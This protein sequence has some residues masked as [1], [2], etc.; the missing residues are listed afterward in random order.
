M[1]NTR[2]RAV[3]S[4]L[5]D[6]KEA[7]RSD[8]ELLARFVA[9]K[10]Q[11]AFA[12]LVQRHG[13]LVLGVCRRVLQHDADAE[14]AFQAT[15]LLLARK[16]PAIRKQASVASWLHGVARRTALNARRS[17]MRRR[18]HEQT[19]SPPATSIAA[20][21]ASLHELQSILDE[22]V[23]RLPERYRAPFVLCC[24]EGHGRPEAAQALG[25]SEGTVSSRLARA[26]QR[27]QDRLTRRGI[28]LSTALC[29]VAVTTGESKAALSQT[30]ASA[31]AKAAT[32]FASGRLPAGMVSD[33]AVAWT[34][35]MLR[36]MTV[37]KLAL[38]GVMLL[39]LVSLGGLGTF[40]LSGE[41][42]ADAS[43]PAASQPE[44]K[45]PAPAKAQ[46]SAKITVKSKTP[47]EGP[48]LEAEL[49]LTNDGDAPL[50]LC[51]LVGH[52]GSRTDGRDETTYQPDW[53]K[54]DSPTDETSAKHIVTL[55][56]GESVAIPLAFGNVR[57]VKGKFTVV[58]GYAVGKE[59]AQKHGTWSGKVMAAPV[60]VPIQEVKETG[61]RE[62]V[63]VDLRLLQ[64]FFS[65]EIE[66]GKAAPKKPDVDTRRMLKYLKEAPAD[67]DVRTTAIAL[68]RKYAK[69][70]DFQKKGRDND[71]TY[72]SHVHQ[73]LHFAW[74]V[75]EATAVLAPNMKLDDF[76]AILGDS[77]R[78][79][80]PFTEWH[81]QS[82][83]H[84]NPCLAC[85]VKDGV[86]TSVEITR[87]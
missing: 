82:I 49:L 17:I 83:M 3:L 46:L 42:P 85:R 13:G 62:Q 63:R 33:R 87:R 53:W 78:Q 36:I 34:R 44:P 79:N 5:S 77:T 71:S 74:T 23:E 1:V 75:L 26:R 22:E 84:V 24:L 72:H 47:L 70:A 41:L 68:A 50:R 16:A 56:P 21:A 57:G 37:R 51:T 69:V 64:D 15:F 4:S 40:C 43:V 25:C 73:K 29:A 54:S 7:A 31:A 81:Y 61:P 65:Q 80:G 45:Q 66:P 67:D 35:A 76:V 6:L 28:T 32:G 59:F 20:S 52:F 10:D 39:V 27:L 60:E 11:E 14:D 2:L 12:T 9:D 30:L 55:K 18:H 38:A 8:G 19:A 86:I 58:A 48:K